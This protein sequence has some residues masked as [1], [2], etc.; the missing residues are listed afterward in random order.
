MAQ[1]HPNQKKDQGYVDACRLLAQMQG[2]TEKGLW[3]LLFIAELGLMS[4]FEEWLR[5]MK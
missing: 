1:T 2:S 3:A 4:K 5:R